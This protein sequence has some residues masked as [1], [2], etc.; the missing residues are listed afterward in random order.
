MTQGVLQQ[1]EQEVMILIAKLNEINPLTAVLN[2]SLFC[3][4]LFTLFYANRTTV[5]QA[6]KTA[7]LITY[8][9]HVQ[10]ESFSY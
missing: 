3:I 4:L 7:D 2:S 1:T 8:D 9:L 6:C 10:G 5:L